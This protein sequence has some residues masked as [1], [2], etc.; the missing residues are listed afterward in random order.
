MQSL[1]NEMGIP[2]LWHKPIVLRYASIPVTIGK[3]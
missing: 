2:T 3:N 1:L